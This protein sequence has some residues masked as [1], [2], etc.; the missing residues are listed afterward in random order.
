[1]QIQLVPALLA[2]NVGALLF[3]LALT[4]IF[5]RVYCSV[6]CPMG[7]YQDIINSLS[8]KTQKKKRFKYSKPLNWLRWGI[9]AATILAFFVGFTFLVGLLDPY[10]AFAR[11]TVHVIK[12]VYLA[13]NNLLELIFTS[14]GNHTFYR[15]SVYLLSVTSLIIALVTVIAV[16][17][18]AATNGRSYCNSICPV[19]T[20]LGF[21]SKF[22]IF[23]IRINESTCNSCGKCER[24]CKASCIDAKNHKIDYSRCVDCFDCINVCSKNAIS[25]SYGTQTSK[26]N[27]DID[28]SKRNFLISLGL[29]G[30][31]AGKVFAD[32]KYISHNTNNNK[33]KTPLSP[34]GSQSH[35]N[36]L[37]HCTSCHL[38]VSKCPANI[39]K[40]A[41]TQYGLSGIMQPV[42]TFEH[43]FCNY[44][45][46]LC[47]EIC[48]NGAIQKLTK[49]EKHVLQVG[50]VNFVKE[51]CIVYTEETNCGACSE[52]CPTQAVSM[53]PYKDELDIPNTNTDLCV[54][55]GGCEYICPAKPHKAIYVDGLTRHN[56]LVFKEEKT[57]KIKVDD[58]GF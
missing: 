55:C 41:F 12:P 57:E 18:M 8:V 56:K 6:I 2:L 9:V 52:H 24:T 48:P 19:G 43:G 16:G 53:V 21:L 32:S 39:L 27:D 3:V 33:A 40:P 10:S 42:M 37:S 1:M 44:D 54:G 4:I 46:T 23:K 35:E 36:L 49:E 14:F 20:T 50:K 45:C 25:F 51:N 47:S 26:K 34:P 13:G 28:N 17:I 5:G 29:T 30:I 11:I 7:F 31:A 22:S 58:F 38:C 15:M